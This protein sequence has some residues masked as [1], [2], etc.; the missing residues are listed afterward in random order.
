MRDRVDNGG[1]VTDYSTVHN[2]LS[3]SEWTPL[4]LSELSKQIVRATLQTVSSTQQVFTDIP[5]SPI[6]VTAKQAHYL[7]QII[8]ELT[9]NSVKYARPQNSNPIIISVTNSH[10][11]E[12][13]TVTLV[14]RDNGPGYPLEM[15]P[16][17]RK[18]ESMGMELVHHLIINNLQGHYTLQND[19]GA[20]TTITFQQNSDVQPPAL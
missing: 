11:P 4:S 18:Y 2:L 13:S 5:D 1:G 16:Q 3:A 17:P 14:Y 10:Q 7:A 20:V 6:N 19:N 15:L 8:T 9:T 12:T